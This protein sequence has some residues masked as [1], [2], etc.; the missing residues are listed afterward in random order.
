MSNKASFRLLLAKT[1]PNTNIDSGVVA[2]ASKLT[3]FSMVEG[4]RKLVKNKIK[5]RTAAG[6]IGFSAS[7]LKML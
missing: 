4:S 5:P 3:V 6:I 1:A 7:N 2:D